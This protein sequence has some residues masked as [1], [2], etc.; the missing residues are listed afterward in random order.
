MTPQELKAHLDEAEKNPERV[1]SALEGLDDATLGYKPAPDG[2]SILEIL[3]H[4]ADIEIVYGYRIRQVLADKAPTF[5]P[6]D[7][8][9]WARH[10]GYSEAQAAEM[11]ALYRT[12]RRGNLRLL[13]RVTPDQLVKGGFHPELNRQVT[14]AEWIERLAIHGANHLGQIE[15]IK[16]QS[17]RRK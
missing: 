5:A 12:N 8:K 6:I 4:L 16:Q 15:K 13:R 17:A 14:L 11:L 9:D 10:L 7:Q 2:W 1:A 3:G